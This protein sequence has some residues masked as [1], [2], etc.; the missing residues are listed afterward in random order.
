MSNRARKQRKNAGLPLVSSMVGSL[1]VR[2][3]TAC[4]GLALLAPPAAADRLVRSADV[5]AH[6]TARSVTL[7]NAAIE[8]RWSRA[9]LRT[10]SLVDRRRPRTAWSSGGRDF[11]L[12]L[13]GGVEIA[14]DAFRAREVELGELPGGGLRIAMRLAPRGTATAL[15]PGL[16]IART[17]EL[18]PRVAVLRTQTTIRSAVPLLLAGATLDEVGVGPAAP[19][20]HAFRAG[21]DWREPAWPGPPLALGDPHA[22]D[23]RDTRSAP[24]GAP[25]SGPGQW[26]SLA[27]DGRSLFMVLERND[28]PSSR[29]EYDGRA[30]RV[31]VDFG[32]DVL[33]LGPF[34]EQAHLESPLPPA[35][36]GRA[37]LVR[38]GTALEL[39]TAL[40][41]VGANAD[42][43]PW[44]AYRAISPPSP[45]AVV[46]NSNGVDANLRSTGAKDDVDLATVEQLAPVARRL[47]VETFVL[48]DGWQ[49]VSGDWEPDSP[50][51]PEPRW[52]GNPES[53]LRP[54]FPDDRFEAV[55]R[56]IAPMKLGLWMSPLHFN[57]RARAYREHPDWACSPVGH[58][59]ALANALDPDSGSNEAGIGQ[60]SAAALP[61][62]ESRIREAI[63]DWGV[64]Y[65]KFDFLAWLD[66]AGE[67]DLYDLHDAFLALID[68][69]RRDHPGVTFQIDET[70]DYRLWPFESLTRGPV[71]FQNGAPGLAR[72]LH[73]LWALSP[74][75]PT[76]AIGQGIPTSGHPVDT[77]LAA[78]LPTHVTFFD[79]I[80][81]LPDAFVE[82]AGRWLRF[83]RDHRELL[84]GMAY[85][86][87]DDPLA[88]GW[89]ALQVWNPDAG[90]GA[91]LVF[92]QGSPD[93]ERTIALRAFRGPRTLYEAPD[94]EAVGTITDGT[95]HVRIP[96]PD[97]AL[98]LL[99]R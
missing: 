73:N 96:Q 36:P 72:L 82:R 34:E 45:R 17:V 2:M 77:L 41:G 44:Q 24:A 31:R 22:G 1:V 87:L 91:L 52:D 88:G 65:F 56:A 74:Y 79:D 95:V 43:E 12:R 50:A 54:R 30:A 62:V 69:L 11:T 28:L 35:A 68:R 84:G 47:G 3:A 61:H 85:P 7:R 70:N 6:V 78:A 33:V 23:W 66:C 49:A 90:E 14:S 20:L 64:R 89:T 81:E 92:R 32:R 27:R 25:L 71:W 39:G 16:E 8:R 10:T 63:E 46:F 59:L 58:G 37:R 75:V 60:W 98:V 67:G 57:P 29:A 18:R 13:A 4:V 40:T 53:K 9:P 55:R 19:T 97:G 83:Y 42:D 99:I 48:D 80:R 93:A 21:G 94:G 51:H 76:Y 26:L 15:V 38:P 86:L 5:S